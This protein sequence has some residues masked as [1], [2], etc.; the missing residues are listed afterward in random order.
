MSF[1]EADKKGTSSEGQSSLS[2]TSMEIEG[3]EY[4]AIDS[5]QAQGTGQLS[6]EEGE[7]ITVLE[8]MEDG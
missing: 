7:V 6:F 1:L 5:Y 4:V 3:Q 2:P 8:K